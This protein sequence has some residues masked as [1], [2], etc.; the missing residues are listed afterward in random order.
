LVVATGGCD[1]VDEYTNEG[2]LCLTQGSETTAISV[3]VFVDGYSSGCSSLESS[4][5]AVSRDGQTLTVTSHMRV[6]VGGECFDDNRAYHSECSLVGAPAGEYTLRHGDFET[7]ITL[8]LPDGLWSTETGP[9]HIR[10][11]TK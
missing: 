7:T 5:C 9:S 6:T 3:R 8:P 10:R 2:S 4:R 11:C 1:G